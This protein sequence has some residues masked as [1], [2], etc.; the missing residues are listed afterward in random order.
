MGGRYGMSFAKGFIEKGAYPE[1]VAS[2]TSEI[3][4]GAPGPEPWFDRGTA[5]EL[6]ERWA[7][8]V[9]D[10]ERA[11]ALNEEAREMDP[12]A[13]DDAYFSAALGAAQSERPSDLGRA[14]TRL[15]RYRELCPEGE[16]VAESKD[17]ERRLRGELPSLLDKTRSVD[18]V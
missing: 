1:A 11:I 5:L 14:L 3:E 7:D 10:F 8:A 17:W 9:S 13:L 18:A 6:L 2:A 12:F 15:S 4:A 16:H